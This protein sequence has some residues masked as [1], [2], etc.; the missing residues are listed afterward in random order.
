[1]KLDRTHIDK[2][3][4][5]FEKTN[6]WRYLPTSKFIEQNENFLNF[7]HEIFSNNFLGQL[8]NWHAFANDDFSS[9][10]VLYQSTDEPAWFIT[11]ILGHGDLT[12]IL[13]EAIKF[14][15][16]TGRF[17]FYVAIPTTLTGTIEENTLN[18]IANNYMFFDEGVTPAQ[19]KNFYSTYWQVLYKRTMPSVDTLTRC[20]LLK[21]NFRQELPA[22]GSL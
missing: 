18:N 2:I 1:M 21:N 11:D 14:N 15:E 16:K 22:I 5:L 20:Y 10:L 6:D 19:T 9:G 4:T 13:T 7:E 17:K 3:C 8:K 12:E